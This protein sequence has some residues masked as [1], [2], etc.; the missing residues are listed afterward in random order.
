MRAILIDWV[1]SVTWQFRLAPETL[2]LAIWVLD[3]FFEKHQVP[4]KRLQLAGATAIFIAGKFEEVYYPSLADF[5]AVCDD[6]YKGFEFLK[7]EQQ[8][9]KVIDFQLDR[10]LA[11]HFLRR[12]SKAS[13]ADGRT[14]MMGKYLCEL[15]QIDYECAQWKPSLL[16]AT[17]LYVSLRLHK[18]DGEVWSAT[19]EHYTNYS[20]AQV[21]KHAVHLCQLLLNAPNSKQQVRF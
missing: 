16:A 10:P 15:A 14:H 7:M 17:A 8:I 2:Y 4:K 13:H 21:E 19:T 11:P 9:L 20:Q 18:S 1:V 12:G 3:R 5:V 6:L